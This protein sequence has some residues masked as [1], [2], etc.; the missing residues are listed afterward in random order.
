MKK[1]LSLGSYVEM[2]RLVENRE[3]WLKRQGDIALR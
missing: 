2:K 1:L 3:D